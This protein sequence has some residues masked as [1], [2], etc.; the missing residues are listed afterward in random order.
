LVKTALPR[1]W[2]GFLEH[3]RQTPSFT[4]FRMPHWQEALK[5]IRTVPGIVLITALLPW[6]WFKLRQDFSSDSTRRPEIILLA[7]I[8][9]ALG[10]VVASLSVLTPN[11]I[12]IA[13]YLQPVIVAAY[14][15]L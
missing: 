11:T 4:G 2:A 7:A 8:L 6:S 13:N 1:A 10:I 14:L 15:W 3:A 9:P 5:I 12:A